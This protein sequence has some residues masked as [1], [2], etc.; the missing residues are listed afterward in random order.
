M[1]KDLPSAPYALVVEDEGLIRMDAVDILEQAG[2]RT[3][4][5]VTGDHAA[6]LLRQHHQDVVL[7]FT[8]VE[9]PGSRNGFTLARETAQAYPHI[10]I[11]VASGRVTPGPDDLPEGARFIAKPFS[12]QIVHH[13]VRKVMPDDHMPSQ[14]KT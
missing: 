5:A 7:L 6:E 1:E 10:S 14:L 11:V 2:F 3:L 8:D 13:H 9:M 4:E 12:A